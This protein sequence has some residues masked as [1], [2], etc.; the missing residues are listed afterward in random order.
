MSLTSTL[1]CPCD[2]SRPMGFYYLQNQ[3]QYTKKHQFYELKSKVREQDRKFRRQENELAQLRR[4]LVVER[5]SH[6]SDNDRKNHTIEVYRTF[7]RERRSDI[8]ELNSKIEELTQEL[9]NKTEKIQRI[10][11]FMTNITS[12]T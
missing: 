4:S 10:Q 2:E 1:I 11:D 5:L 3:H 9:A 8:E 7:L 12:M 6:Q